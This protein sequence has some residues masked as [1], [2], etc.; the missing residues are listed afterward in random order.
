MLLARSP[1]ESESHHRVPLSRRTFCG[2][3]IAVVMAAIAGRASTT[4]YANL[5]A[6]AES[7]SP[8]RRRV[9]AALVETVADDPSGRLDV[10]G[11]ADAFE[12]RYASETPVFRS[13]ANILL[14][15][16]EEEEKGRVPLS[17]LPT[18]E[19]FMRLTE[20]L[21]NEREAPPKSSITAGRRRGSSRGIS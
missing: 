5:L 18:S 10:V 1:R 11:L 3:G 8:Q 6:P 9:Y 20:R 17:G 21:V 4:S 13:N 2:A 7:L 19:R 15:F 16:V 12:E 14:D